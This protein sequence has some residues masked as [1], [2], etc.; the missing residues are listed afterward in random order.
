MP[1]I[2]VPRETRKGETRVAAV[3]GTVQRLVK[4]GF[5]VTVETGAGLGSMVSDESLA[6]A[7]AT[8]VEDPAAGYAAADVVLRV[9]PP[10]LEEVASLKSG[11]LLVSHVW[12]FDKKA[13]CEKLMERGVT[14]FAMDQIP[15]TTKA[16]YMD[17]LSSQMSL[18]GYKAVLLAAE[19]LPTTLPLMMTAAGTINLNTNAGL[20]KVLKRLLAAGLD[21]V[22]VSI[23]SLRPACY[24]AYFRP[25][26]RFQDVIE[27]IDTALDH[28]AF[29]AINYLNCPG[30][31]DATEEVAALMGF[32]AGHP[33]HMIQWRN[34][35]FDPLRYHR[36]MA[37]AAPSTGPIGMANLL[38][39]VRRRFAGLRFGYFN[40]PKEAFGNALDR[41]QGI[42]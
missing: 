35:N 12:P 18:A 4:D 34:L 39:R 17:S 31:T 13:L 7:G 15:R 10:T 2:F 27:S 38:A 32:L 22:R 20:P 24:Q 8:L 26:Y 33:I 40:P 28:G 41:S 14:V 1:R 21:S 9:N 25:R 30:F 29:V 37:E 6:K 23:N 16:Q 36:A 5:E 19:H 42:F 11:G 3:V